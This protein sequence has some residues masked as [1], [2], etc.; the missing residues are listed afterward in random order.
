MGVGQGRA[1]AAE[2]IEGSIVVGDTHLKGMSES[3]HPNCRLGPK[4]KAAGRRPPVGGAL[5]KGCG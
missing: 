4:E 1:G 3:L 5:R 2:F